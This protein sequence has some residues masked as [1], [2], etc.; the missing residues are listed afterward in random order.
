[1]TFRIL[2]GPVLAFA[3]L[4]CHRP[5]SYDIVIRGGTLIDGTGA[6]GRRGDLAIRGDSIIALGEV[7]GTASQTI[8]ATG[9][10][11]SP[12]FLLVAEFK[13]SGPLQVPYQTSGY[14]S[15]WRAKEF[16]FHSSHAI[17]PSI[18]ANAQINV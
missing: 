4:G 5:A 6:A 18:P 13:T 12:G 17:A 10:V 1:M 7:T 2:R 11:V 3:L 15:A 8:D 9:M 16:F 14:T